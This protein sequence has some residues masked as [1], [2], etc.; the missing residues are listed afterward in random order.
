LS[1]ASIKVGAVHT[2]NEVFFE[3]V[4]IPSSRVAGDVN[5][6]WYN[7]AVAL[8]FERSS[9]QM[10][11][12]GRRAIERIVELLRDHSALLKTRPEI[13]TDIAD[14][15]IELSVSRLMSYQIASMQARGQVPNRE[16]SI[17]K[18]FGCELQQRISSTGMR[19]LGMLGQL[20]DGSKHQVMDAA[21]LY[22]RS[23]P[24]TIAGGTSEINRSVIA[25]RGIGLARG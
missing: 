22:V 15:S 16:A 20:R 7:L 5:R 13:R 18:N 1:P 11:G 12:A 23:I 21:T 2:L 8:D 17:S 10:S 6:G 25:T 9:I 4:R 3:D 14:R 24:L 19:V